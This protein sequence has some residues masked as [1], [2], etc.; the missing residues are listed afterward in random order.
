MWCSVVMDVNVTT[1][2][3]EWVRAHGGTAAIDF[4][5]PIG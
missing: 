1:D 2:A 3:I 5:P 4:I